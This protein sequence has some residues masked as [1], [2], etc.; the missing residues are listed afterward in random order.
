MREENEVPTL[1]RTLSLLRRPEATALPVRSV[2]G[3][4]VPPGRRIRASSC[5]STK[6]EEVLINKIGLN[7]EAQMKTFSLKKRFEE[8]L[9]CKEE[10]EL[11]CKEEVAT[12][13]PYPGTKNY[14]K[15]RIAS[16]DH[17]WGK[18]AVKRQKSRKHNRRVPE[19]LAFLRELT[20][21]LPIAL[22]E[23]LE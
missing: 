18:L 19:D 17:R 1:H 11:Y 20:Y 12:T 10:V 8:S 3:A 22:E 4:G 6:I 15:S 7:S 23:G 9:H 2:F 5:A 13:L 21:T 16:P 14:P